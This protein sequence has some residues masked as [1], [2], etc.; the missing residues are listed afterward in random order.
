MRLRSLEDNFESY[1]TRP[2]FDA[3]KLQRWGD[4]GRAT[5]LLG[6]QMLMASLLWETGCAFVDGLR[7]RL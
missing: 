1:D 4:M 2:L 5:N 3:R 6:L 7:L